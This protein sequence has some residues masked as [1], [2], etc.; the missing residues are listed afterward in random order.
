MHSNVRHNE[1][2]PGWLY[3]RLLSVWLVR[4]LGLVCAISPA[5]VQAQDGVKIWE[6]SPYQVEVLV[7]FDASVTA[8]EPAKQRWLQRVQAELERSFRAAWKVN[9]QRLPGELS[10]NLLRDFNTITTESLTANEWVLVLS[11]QASAGKTIHTLDAALS[12]LEEIHCTASA[13]ALLL[14]LADSLQLDDES[15]TRKLLAKCVVEAAGEAAVEARLTEGTIAAALVSRSSLAGLESA[16]R[17]IATPLPWQS[18]YLWRQRDKVFYLV[19]RSE[20]DEIMVEVRELDCPMQFLGPVVRL[21]SGEWAYSARTAAAATTLAFAAVARVEEA[22]SKTAE[23][24]LRAGGLIV[25]RDNPATIVAGDV[26]QPIVRRDD[27]NGVP[28]LLQPL[29]WTYA[30]ITLSDGVKLQAN[31]YSYSGGPGLQGQ[32]NRRTQ[33]VLL[34]VRPQYEQTD[35]QLVLRGSGR[36]Q[37]GCAIYRRDLLTD[38]F[39]LLG[40]TDWRGRLQIDMSQADQGFLPELV[41]LERLRAKRAAEEAAKLAQAGGEDNGEGDPDAPHAADGDAV[42]SSADTAAVA[43]QTAAE[44]A[45]QPQGN[46]LDQASV[47]RLRAPLLQLYVKHGDQ[48]LAKLPLVPGMEQ[49]A[50]AEIPDD[51][52]R[53]KAE[54]FVTGFQADVLDLVGLR[55]LLATQVKQYLQNDRIDAAKVAVEKMRQLK[56]YTEMADQLESIQRRMLEETDGPI[57]LAAKSRIDLMFQATRTMLQKYLQDN[58]LS[59]AERAVEAAL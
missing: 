39:T 20:L 11:Q 24:Q 21:R 9:V 13:Q 49:V 50:V 23:L 40:Q 33:R 42:D 36:S 54:A 34:K 5:V 22:D 52:R 17:A 45:A 41:R 43:A 53:L 2:L 14:Q 1:L 15:S 10:A 57:P 28:T 6:F 56:N 30:A 16:A 8:S 37:A 31:V 19:V 32:R 47:I 27:R 38:E 4:C 51:S 46:P 7:A 48:I 35:I 58:L 59:E 29:P 55:R 12:N 44:I 3:A 26:M 25:E 18:D